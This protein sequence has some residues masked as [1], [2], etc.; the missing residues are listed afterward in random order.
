M[1]TETPPPV[2]AAVICHNEQEYIA[3]C[4]HS[5]RWCE[6]V[7]LVDSGS[8]DATLEIARGFPNVEIATRPFDNFINQKN[9][10]LSLCRQE[11]VVSLDADEVLTDP[12]IEEIRGLSFEKAGYR[13]GRRSFIGAREIKHGT[14]SPDYQLRLFRKS[15]SCWGDQSARN[16]PARWGRRQIGNPH[17]PL[18][19][20]QPPGIRRTQYPVYPHDGGPSC[21]PG[22]HRAPLGTIPALRG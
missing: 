7:V 19:L 11:W 6:Q 10:A 1:S 15:R 13:I 3:Q 4:L 2:S 9:F 20:P 21:R 12:L 22:T 14:W 18:Q 5:L 17:A 16:H 8:T